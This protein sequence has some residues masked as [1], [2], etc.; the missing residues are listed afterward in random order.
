MSDSHST[1]PAKPAKPSPDFPLFPHV[2]GRWAK[3]IKGRMVY[4][5]PW[6]DPQAALQAYQD[7]VAGKPMKRPLPKQAPGKPSKPY[8]DFPLFAHATGRWAKKIR[9]KLHYFGPWDD[10]QGALDRYLAVKDELHAGRKPRQVSAGVTVKDLANAFLHHKQTRV[11]SGELSPL[12]WGKYKQA[13]DLIVAQLGKT[14]LVEDIGPDDFA[15]LRTTMTRRW[16]VLRV[17]DMIQAVRSVFKFGFE[18]GI[19]AVPV[20][21][22]P[23]FARPS[24]KTVRLHRAQ[25]GPKLFTAPQ[26][27]AMLTR[28]SVPMRAMILLGINAGLGNSDC[29]QLPV[30]ALDLAGGWMTYPRPKTGAPRRA[31]LW[32]ETVA[33][34][35]EA[36]AQRPEAKD[37]AVAGLVFITRYGKSWHK[38]IED[39]PVA[40]EMAK[41][42]KLLKLYRGR[43]LGFYTLRHCFETVGGEA[44]DQVT[45]DHIMGHAKDD[46]ASVYRERISDERLQA[47]AEHVRAWLFGT[48]GGAR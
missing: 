47:V 17:R 39:S 6:A 21:F 22:G 4:F 31:K 43:G 48:E 41:L 5:G 13:T 7:F 18:A 15:P 14:R 1:A 23:G 38:T 46:M 45:V 30:K 3:K 29:G 27:R 32:P 33:A 34:I 10:P 11:D 40:K 12:T 24:K 19:I 25:R 9:G 28:A 16:G 2:T 26:I 36:L 8:P 44:R 37:P 35:R 20:R 42:L